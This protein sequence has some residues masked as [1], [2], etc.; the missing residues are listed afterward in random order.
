MKL[1]VPLPSAQPPADP[2]GALGMSAAP[3]AMLPA[4]VGLEAVMEA[5][6]KG[7][8]PV[9]TGRGWRPGMMPLILSNGGR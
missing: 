7:G 4:P 5:L 9:G 8:L 2:G 6:A 3:G 1:N